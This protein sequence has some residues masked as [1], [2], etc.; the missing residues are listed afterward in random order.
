MLNDDDLNTPRQQKQKPSQTLQQSFLRQNFFT[1][2]IK[3]RTLTLFETTYSVW[4][5]GKIIKNVHNLI[6]IF[7]TSE[8]EM[9]ELWLLHQIII[10]RNALDK[11]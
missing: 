5:L 9:T 8:I 2:N 6:K 7:N 10:I 4:L 3:L 11:Q 1:N